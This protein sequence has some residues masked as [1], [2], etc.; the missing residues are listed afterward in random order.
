MVSRTPGGPG[1]VRKRPHTRPFFLFNDAA[2]PPCHSKQE[3]ERCASQAKSSGSTTPRV[4]GS[5]NA[6]EAVMSSCTTRLSR[7]T[8]SARRSEEHTSELQSP[9]YLVCR[10]LLEKKNTS[11]YVIAQNIDDV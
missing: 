1:A 9:M 7:A 3:E 10:L 5:S 8:A 2:T 4:T 6:T 11:I